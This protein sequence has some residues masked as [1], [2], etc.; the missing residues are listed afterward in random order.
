MPYDIRN[1]EGKKIGSV[2]T[3]ADTAVGLALFIYLLPFLLVLVILG[4]VIAGIGAGI[5]VYWEWASSTLTPTPYPNVN[6]LIT[7]FGLYIASVLSYIPWE[8][9][10]RGEKEKIK[11][12]IWKSAIILVVVEA[13]LGLLG[14]REGLFFWA[15][16]LIAS[17]LVSLWRFDII[18]A[19]Y[20]TLLELPFLIITVGLLLQIAGLAVG[21]AISWL[22][23]VDLSFI[24][25]QETTSV[26]FFVLSILLGTGWS[27]FRFIKRLS[28]KSK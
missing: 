10:A 24:L 5:P 14:L 13:T 25:Y 9:V 3:P 2:T 19:I 23:S 18:K 17:F 8:C 12:A 7:T 4:L 6:G 28:N 20:K 27:I 21:G 11:D 22:L 15:I 26:I 1:S 16:P